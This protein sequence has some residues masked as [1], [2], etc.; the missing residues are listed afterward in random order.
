MRSISALQ[1][2]RKRFH[3]QGR[4]AV[5]AEFS[6]VSIVPR[7]FWGSA[8][9]DGSRRCGYTYPTRFCLRLAGWRTGAMQ[10]LWPRPLDQPKFPSVEGLTVPDR[11]RQNALCGSTDDSGKFSR[12]PFHTRAASRNALPQWPH[13][14]NRW[15][16]SGTRSASAAEIPTG[17]AGQ[18]KSSAD[19]SSPGVQPAPLA[20]PD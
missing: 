4:P 11:S 10:L 14:L 18:E 19:T 12:S 9:R 16:E 5:E 3:D 2:Q 8:C 1:F 15:A 20:A 6:A 17:R 13:T 7:R